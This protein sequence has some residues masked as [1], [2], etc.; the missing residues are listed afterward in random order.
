MDKDSIANPMHPLAHSAL[1]GGAVMTVIA[2]SIALGRGPVP[3]HQLRDKPFNDALHE[4]IGTLAMNSARI[5]A[6]NMPRIVQTEPIKPEPDPLLMVLSEPQPLP[7]RTRAAVVS[8]DI[9]AKHNMRKVYY[10]STW[11]C[12]K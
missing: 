6:M 5:E 10:G 11:R 1:I 2:A 7:K 12:R 9:C 4:D 3:A 8:G